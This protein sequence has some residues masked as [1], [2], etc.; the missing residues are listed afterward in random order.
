MK[1]FGFLSRP[2]KQWRLVSFDFS[3][4]N[5][6]RRIFKAQQ[7]QVDFKNVIPEHV[8]KIFH[9]I[10]HKHGKDITMFI[11]AALMLTPYGM[12]P[13]GDISFGGN[14]TWSENII[15]WLI[16]GKKMWRDR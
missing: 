7:H 9:L 13:K 5:M 12:G 14:S 15:L 3:S 11:Y 1:A 2:N 16:T 10:A 4:Y 6:D 8:Y